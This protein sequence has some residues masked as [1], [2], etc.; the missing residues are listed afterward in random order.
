LDV[1]KIKSTNDRTFGVRA[2]QFGFRLLSGTPQLA[3][4]CAEAL[5]FTPPRHSASVRTKG[6]LA[7]GHRFTV[8]VGKGRVAAWSWGE[9]PPVVLVHGWG[10]R[11]GQLSAFGPPLVSSGM[12]VVAFDAPGH[13]LSSG[14][15]S[16][17]VH[18]AEAL[19]TLASIM[20]PRAIVAHSLGATAVALALR[21]GLTTQRA[22]FLGPPA[23]PTQWVGR[24][25]ER[26]GIAPEAI[27]AMQALAERRLQFKW[28][29]LGI[30][31]LARGQT[32]PLLVIHDVADAEVPWVHG[33]EVARVWPG[34]RFLSTRGLGH[35]R[36]LR[37]A[38]VVAKTVEFLTGRPPI[39]EPEGSDCRPETLERYLYERHSRW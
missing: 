15:R 20:P 10:G 23:E 38:D 39:L 3:G 31:E 4:R 17:V 9:G 12:Q 6:F 11:A 25:A 27:R 1:D 16:S 32:I 33:A 8:R 14:R 35:R 18:F 29:H 26:F 5:F 34:A 22:V 36:I 30:T 24:L 21:R 13:G 19:Q 28:S 2:A 37:D 7:T